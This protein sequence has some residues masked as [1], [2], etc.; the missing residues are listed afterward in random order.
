[1]IC[2]FAD[3]VLEVIPR[4][5]A[6]DSLPDQTMYHCFVKEV[7]KG[8]ADSTVDVVTFPGAMET[9][10][11]YILLLTDGGGVL[12]SCALNSVFPAD[13]PEAETIRGLRQPGK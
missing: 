3:L 10:Q 13:S 6:D 2:G 9:G 4:Q 5:I 12:E 1:M 8:R 11:N 7:L